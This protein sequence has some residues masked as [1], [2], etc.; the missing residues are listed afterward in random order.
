MEIAW[1]WVRFQPRSALT[2]WYQARFGGGGA[3]ARRIGIVALARRVIIA[4]WRYAT[5]DFCRRAPCSKRNR[6]DRVTRRPRPE[7]GSRGDP[8]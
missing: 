7:E 1:A 5:T 8:G 2:Q 6:G 4:L 3:V